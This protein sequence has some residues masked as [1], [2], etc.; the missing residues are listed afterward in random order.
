M[1]RFMPLAA[2]L[3]AFFALSLPS[4]AADLKI[5]YMDSQRIL[6]DS[7]AGKDAYKQLEVLKEERQQEIDK[8]QANLKRM[9][10]E[11]AAKGLSMNESARL[12]L[13][14]NY[15]NELKKYNRF[16]KDAQE[17][18]RRK[19]LTLIKPI[20]DEVSAIIDEYGDQHTIDIILDRRD[21]GIIYTS[22]KLDITDA[23][24][25]LYNKQYKE[26]AGKKK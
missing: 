23:I 22:D 10:D 7:L 24:L 12:D 20:S 18:L 15:D 6:T 19:E 11:M 16:V 13:Q 21:P 17:E 14:S 8:M 26:T 25:E 9:T 2:A 5:Y 1:K 4:H 3:I